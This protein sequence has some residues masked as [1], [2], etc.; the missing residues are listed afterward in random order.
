MKNR[1]RLVCYAVVLS[2]II[3]LPAAVP[4]ERTSVVRHGKADHLFDQLRDLELM[5]RNIEECYRAEKRTPVVAC[6]SGQSWTGHAELDGALIIRVF[7]H[8]AGTPEYERFAV[9]YRTLIQHPEYWRL[10]TDELFAEY[11]RLLE[12]GRIRFL[13]ELKQ[14]QGSL[15][16]DGWA[17]PHGRF[18]QAVQT[19]TA[20][21]PERAKTA[22][23]GRVGPLRR[24]DV[25]IPSIGSAFFVVP[26]EGF[27][28][29]AT[30]VY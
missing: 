11:M 14:W 19:V 13:T 20:G 15:A 3:V 6:W 9:A 29:V 2:I 25:Q 18:E 22:Q 5:Q 10:H 21:Y 27:S 8:L 7:G 23:S 26:R 1:E 17:Q 16:E 4:S 24:E 30:P 28:K 12:S